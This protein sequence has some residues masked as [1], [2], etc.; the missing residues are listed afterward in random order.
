MPK[1][2]SLN[3]LILLLRKKKRKEKRKKREREI[4]CNNKNVF[5]SL[6]LFNFTTP[7]HEISKSLAVSNSLLSGFPTIYTPQVHASLF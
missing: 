2:K 4:N 3:I 7:L 1:D 5:R 6:D